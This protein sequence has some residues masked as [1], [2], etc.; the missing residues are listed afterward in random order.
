VTT[1]AVLYVANAGT[2]TVSAYNVDSAGALTPISSGTF[3]T[4]KGPSSVL[5]MGPQIL[6]VANNG[7]SDDISAFMIGGR[8][9]PVSR[10]WH[11]RS[12]LAGNPLSLAVAWTFLYSANPDATRPQHIGLQR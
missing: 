1:G 10:I 11:R 12:P 6:F 4:G 7:G 8:G 9:C 3:A 5:Q 2:D